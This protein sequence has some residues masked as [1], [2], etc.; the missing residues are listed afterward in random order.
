[1]QYARFTKQTLFL[2]LVFSIFPG[3]QTPV[4][5]A[6]GDNG[7]CNELIVSGLEWPPIYQRANG[8]EPE[9]G[10]GFNLLQ[11]IS[12]TLDIPYSIQTEKPFA[13]EIHHLKA[14]RTDLSLGLFPAASR[15]PFFY[16]T[17]PYYNEY[18]YAYTRT[19][20][21]L[22]IR[23]FEDLDDLVGIVIRGSRHGTA[24]N[25]YLESH[26]NV[27]N[28]N[29]IDQAVR[30]ILSGRAD[31]LINS[32][33]SMSTHLAK[34]EYENKMSQSPISLGRH[35]WSMALSKKSPCRHIVN[36]INN[37]ILDRLAKQK[38]SD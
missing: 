11:A 15:L 34:K 6:S 18:L 14:G 29:S 13:R 3:V 30:M 17:V 10:L 26:D 25:H 31:F 19:D 5:A 8:S 27:I 24:L 37:I 9:R 12:K 2:L 23:S 20:R 1:V 7:I 36:D 21:N 35:Q 22:D 38:A 16:F 4:L 28:I 33:A 32:A